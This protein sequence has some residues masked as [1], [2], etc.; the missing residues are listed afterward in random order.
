MVNNEYKALFEDAVR[1]VTAIR[2]YWDPN[3][4]YPE[5]FLE[6]F[7]QASGGSVSMTKLKSIYES[8]KR[9]VLF[10]SVLEQ[11]MHF[12][13]RF[14]GMWESLLRRNRDDFAIGFWKDATRKTHIDLCEQKHFLV[15]SVDELSGDYYTAYLAGVPISCSVFSVEDPWWYRYRERQITLVYDL[16]ECELFG[17]SSRDCTTSFFGDWKDANMRRLISEFA[18]PPLWDFEAMVQFKPYTR[19]ED[20]IAQTKKKDNNDV[21][22]VIVRGTPCA[23]VVRDVA[24]LRLWPSA[25]TD[26]AKFFRLPVYVSLGD[27]LVL[28]SDC[29]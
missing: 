8:I 14:G 23:I 13:C 5:K 19:K 20:L 7:Q 9:P 4:L 21:G 26:F 22:E 25:V 18:M 17:S 24:H 29:Q 27:K 15:H 3:N 16:G 11:L 1:L 12:K 6:A 10:D 28:Y 2:G